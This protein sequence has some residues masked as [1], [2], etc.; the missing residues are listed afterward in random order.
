VNDAGHRL[1]H[2]TTRTTVSSTQ[3]A[4]QTSRARARKGWLSGFIAHLSLGR[5]ERPPQVLDNIGNVPALAQHQVEVRIP[6]QLPRMIA[7]FPRP[8]TGA[9]L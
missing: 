6:D 5:Q 1:L 9:L 3:T 4:D 7:P 8:P 2:N